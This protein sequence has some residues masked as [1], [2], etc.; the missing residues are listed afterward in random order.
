S[1][2]KTLS[3]Y[4]ILAVLLATF[5]TTSFI[6][7]NFLLFFSIIEAQ[8]AQCIQITFKFAFINKLTYQINYIFFLSSWERGLGGEG[9]ILHHN[10][11]IMWYSHST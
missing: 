1:K 2:S 3:S 8:E 7:G 11:R 5:T 9:L 10:F 6:Q 4:S